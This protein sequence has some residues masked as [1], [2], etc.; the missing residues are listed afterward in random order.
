MNK[1]Q[2]LQDSHLSLHESLCPDGLEVQVLL[3]VHDTLVAIVARAPKGL[4]ASRFSA[5]VHFLPNGAARLL[6]TPTLAGLFVRHYHF[7]Q[8]QAFSRPSSCCVLDSC[9]SWAVLELFAYKVLRPAPK[10]GW[11]HVHGPGHF[12]HLAVCCWKCWRWQVSAHHWLLGTNL[13]ASIRV[14]GEVRCKGCVSWCQKASAG[15][16]EKVEKEALGLCA[17]NALLLTLMYCGCICFLRE[18]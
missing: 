18:R 14:F 2:L 8:A 16:R 7:V 17:C 5:L 13:G 3:A 10:L 1:A 15:R 6:F 11:N 12:G 4:E 9:Y